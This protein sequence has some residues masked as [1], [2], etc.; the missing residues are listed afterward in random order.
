M[1]IVMIPVRLYMYTYMCIK[2]NRGLPFLHVEL[3]G[4]F[5]STKGP[6]EQSRQKCPPGK[7]RHMLGRYLTPLYHKNTWY[8]W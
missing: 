4:N 5:P 3:A 8:S 6:P 1:K 7:Q 2:L